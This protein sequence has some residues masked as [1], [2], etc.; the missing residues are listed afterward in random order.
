[1]LTTFIA[2]DLFWL[3]CTIFH[4]AAYMVVPRDG[5]VIPKPSSVSHATNLT[6][7]FCY[8]SFWKSVSR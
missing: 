3:L 1:M 4:N 7:N 6:S 8:A 5:M 2:M